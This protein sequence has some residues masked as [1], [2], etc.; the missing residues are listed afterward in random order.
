MNDEPKVTLVT[1]TYNLINAGSKNFFRQ[2]VESVH[3]RNSL[4]VGD[5]IV[6]FIHGK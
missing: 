5:A 4:F 6:D 3:N 1:I 2:C